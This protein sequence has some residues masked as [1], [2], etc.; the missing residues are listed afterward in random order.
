MCV[1]MSCMCVC[2]RTLRQQH[3]SEEGWYVRLLSL[4]GSTRS[5]MGPRH[6]FSDCDRGAEGALWMTPA[7]EASRLDLPRT[8]APGD[9]PPTSSERPAQL[10]LRPFALHLLLHHVQVKVQV[11]ESIRSSAPLRPSSVTETRFPTV[12]EPQF[13]HLQNGS[14]TDLTGWL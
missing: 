14:N 7:G 12:S 4:H 10:L 3:W 6:I 11:P 2:T 5:P 8:L 13:P 9:R 1:C